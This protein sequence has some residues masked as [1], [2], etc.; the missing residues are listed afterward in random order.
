MKNKK[1]NKK[2]INLGTNQETNN[3][4]VLK[5]VLIIESALE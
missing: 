1:T 3:Q 5:K 4:R 2:E